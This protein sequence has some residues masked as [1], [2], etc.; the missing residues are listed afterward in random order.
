MK[1]AKKPTRAQKTIIS[2]YHLNPE[3]WF[4]REAASDTLTIIHK[5]TNEQRA[6]P[7]VEVTNKNR[8]K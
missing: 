3:K 4:V 1:R 5:F 6:L 2:Y 8:R 7:I